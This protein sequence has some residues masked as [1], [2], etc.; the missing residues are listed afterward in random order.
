[1]LLSTAGQ[2]G[3]RTPPGMGEAAALGLGSEPV[4]LH[5]Q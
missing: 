4:N 5:L 1:M 3:A 2:V